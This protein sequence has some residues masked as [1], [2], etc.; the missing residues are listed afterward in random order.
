MIAVGF[1]ILVG[2][3]SIRE[4]G[5]FWNPAAPVWI[6]A[7]FEFIGL[8]VTLGLMLG[9]YRSLRFAWTGVR[10]RRGATYRV[11]IGVGLFFPA[12]LLS[13]PLT[14]A[15]ANH[16]WPGDGQ[17]ALAALIWSLCIGVAATLIYW[18]I[19][20]IRGLVRRHTD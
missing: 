14:I 7:V 17:S 6:T 3:Y 8:L 16:V 20:G 13:L 18:M 2:V 10:E 15:Y 1:G 11:L 9:G 19:L 4:L 12:A 5:E